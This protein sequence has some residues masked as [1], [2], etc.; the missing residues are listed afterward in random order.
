[1]LWSEGGGGS[2]EKK[3]EAHIKMEGRHTRQPQ[4]SRSIC[5]N[6]KLEVGVSQGDP[7]DRDS[8]L[9]PDGVAEQQSAHGQDAYAHGPH[10]REVRLTPGRLPLT[11]TADKRF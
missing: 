4:G 1:M 6:R 5:A 10:D 7:Q 11:H 8:P 2:D 3:A 9:A